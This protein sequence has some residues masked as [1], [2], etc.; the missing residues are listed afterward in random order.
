MTLVNDTTFNGLPVCPKCGWPMA[1]HHEIEKHRRDCTHVEAGAAAVALAA[2]L[3]DQPS[4]KFG[5]GTDQLTFEPDERLHVRFRVSR[6]GI[7]H[8]EEVWLLDDLTE[9]EAASLVRAIA[10]WR[11]EVWRIRIGRP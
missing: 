9:N 6:A 4:T 5:Y 1:G 8:L 2:R 11:S 10:D 3:P 7:F